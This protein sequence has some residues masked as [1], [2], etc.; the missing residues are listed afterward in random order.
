MKTMLERIVLE[1]MGKVLYFYCKVLKMFKSYVFHIKEY[2]CR[3]E[4]SGKVKAWSALTK[5]VQSSV[6]QC[7]SSAIPLCMVHL[8]EVP[9]QLTGDDIIATYFW[10]ERVDVINTSKRLRIVGRAFSNLEKH[11]LE[12]FPS[13]WPSY[14]YLLCRNPGFAA[15]WQVPKFSMSTNRSHL[16]YQATGW[17][18]QL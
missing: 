18:T 5:T 17:E 7:L 2:A 10:V 15:G 13:S 3:Q 16:K 14:H 12:L 4:N 9:P 1:R 6:S 8:F 11:A